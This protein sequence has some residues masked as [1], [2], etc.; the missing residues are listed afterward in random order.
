M[1]DENGEKTILGVVLV[2]VG[3]GSIF[4]EAFVL[5]C[6][7]S[8]HAVPLFRLPVLGWGSAIGLACIATLLTH[9]QI[10][11][12]EKNEIGSIAYSVIVP[13]IL[14]LMGKLAA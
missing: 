14:L 4:W 7:W 1:S 2:V 9:Q 10:P 3:I 12:D 8:W 13:A 5:R 11:R 6:L